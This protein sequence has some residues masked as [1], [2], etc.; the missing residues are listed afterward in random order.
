MTELIEVARDLYALPLAE[1]T[2]ARNDR[3]KQLREDR[4]LARQVKALPKP[5]TSAWVVNLMARELGEHLD[6]LLDLAAT[7]REAQA[8]GA[9]LRDLDRQRRRLVAALAR[10]G[11]DLA[12]DR[13]QRV[14]GTAL[15]EVEATL[16]AAM[17][18]DDAEAALRSG[19][20]VK[21]MVATGFGAVDVNG[22]VA[23]DGA[24]ALAPPAGS[25]PPL[26]LAPEGPRR[27]P[28]SRA[29]GSPTEETA[30]EDSPEVEPAG[31]AEPPAAETAKDRRERQRRERE[32]RR[33][34]ADAEARVELRRAEAA[35]AAQELSAAEDRL[36]ELAARALQ[37]H[38]EIDELERRLAE[39]RHELETLEGERDEAQHDADDAR[40]AREDADRAL[41][42]AQEALDRLA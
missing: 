27:R 19:I 20:L 35:E 42:E 17:L 16:H 40:D 36:H 37:L 9:D 14:S 13:G 1:F 39:R 2:T 7:I 41:A 32:A 22:V 28:G 4:A 11:R 21:P 12:E 8:G 24:A 26:R 31:R 18:D 33:A 23:V 30:S 38:A 6:R 25:K 29:A 34:R 15:E 10:E 3:A 5:S